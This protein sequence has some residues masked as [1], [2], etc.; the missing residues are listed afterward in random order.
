[1]PVRVH[2][3]FRVANHLGRAGLAFGVLLQS[4]AVP[5]RAAPVP[6]PGL[7]KQAP[8][9]PPPIEHAVEKPTSG[10]LGPRPQGVTPYSIGQ[11]T[12]E[13]QLYLEFLNRMRANPAGEGQRLATATDPNIL[14][15][16]GQFGVDLSLM[17]AELSTNPPV[18]PLAMNAQ[19]TAPGRR[20]RAA[21]FTTHNQA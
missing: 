15:A 11:P 7:P 2:Y 8:P 9:T 21:P 5:L 14:A 19:L 1:M 3:P 20:L 13:E 17:Q 16:Y 4:F 10:G 12:D 18:P 6:S